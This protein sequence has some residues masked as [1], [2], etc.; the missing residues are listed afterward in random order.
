VTD[1]TLTADQQ[2][3]TLTGVEVQLKPE[4]IVADTAA[5]VLTGNNTILAI[6]R[7][8]VA[9]VRSYVWTGN[10]VTFTVTR[11]VPAATIPLAKYGA[12]PI[13]DNRNGTIYPTA[14]F[15]RYLDNVTERVGGNEQP[16]FNS[17]VF[18]SGLIDAAGAITFSQGATFSVESVDAGS[19]KVVW[20]AAQS[21]TNYVCLVQPV[22]A[23]AASRR[24]VMIGTIG[25]DE[26]DYRMLDSAGANAKYDVNFQ[27]IRIS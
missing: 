25:T 16:A 3:Y 18:C 22:N 7:K 19:F 9:S 14:N 26:W 21:D 4:I 12:I 2:T 13:G 8:M 1:Y 24:D 6:H 11:A 17:S 5:Y 20:L 15:S 10:A 27:C 23:S